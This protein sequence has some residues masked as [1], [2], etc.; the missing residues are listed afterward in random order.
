MD[1]FIEAHAVVVVEK[2]VYRDAKNDDHFHLIVMRNCSSSFA[3]GTTI[4]KEHW[5]RFST[6]NFLYIMS[7]SIP[8]PSTK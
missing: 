5:I 1:N 6:T 8:F 3:R 2:I 7:P 4:K